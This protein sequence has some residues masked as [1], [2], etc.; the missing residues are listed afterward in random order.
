MAPKRFDGRE[1][2]LHERQYNCVRVPSFPVITVNVFYIDGAKQ[3]GAPCQRLVT[4]AVPVVSTYGE[5]FPILHWVL[6]VLRRSRKI[7]AS[8]RGVIDHTATGGKTAAQSHVPSVEASARTQCRGWEPLGGL[9]AL[10]C[11]PRGLLPS[12]LSGMSKQQTLRSLEPRA[13]DASHTDSS[14]DSRMDISRTAAGQRQQE[15]RCS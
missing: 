6:L 14:T 9:P 2:V 3:I 13:G 8:T 10:S 11:R 4:Y 5:A 1:W 7:S 15:G 12:D